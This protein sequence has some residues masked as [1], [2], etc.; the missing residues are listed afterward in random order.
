MKSVLLIVAFI[1]LAKQC[2]KQDP[3]AQMELVLNTSFVD[4][5]SKTLNADIHSKDSSIST[6]ASEFL[7]SFEE[8]FNRYRPD[9]SV[10]IKLSKY[11]SRVGIKVVGGNWC[12]DTREQVPK[13]CK[14]LYY[15]GVSVDSFHYYQVDKNK[16]PMEDDFA[17]SWTK[18]PVPDIM[19][20]LDGIEKGRII[21]VPRG[22]MEEDLLNILK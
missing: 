2:S 17:A 3:Y 18:G 1:G 10:A 7:A 13:L 20:Y 5:M 21:E 4:D 22:R 9:K 15:M 16:K 6:W 8:G 12:S 11:K 19:V 14:V